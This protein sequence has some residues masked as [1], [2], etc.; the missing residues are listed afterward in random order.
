MGQIVIEDP[1]VL[2]ALIGAVSGCVV[3]ILFPLT[4]SWLQNRQLKRKIR[5]AFAAEIRSVVTVTQIAGLDKLVNNLLVQIEDN[6]NIKL[7]NIFVSELEYDPIFSANTNNVGLLEPRIA[8]EVVSF[9]KLTRL[10]RFRYLI[11]QGKTVNDENREHV[12]AT[13]SYL[14]EAVESIDRYLELVATL[15]K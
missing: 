15:E 3:G 9:Y 2:A 10:N 4:F 6:L 5:R 8:A 13:L 11:I 14:K 12:I 1:T 7:P